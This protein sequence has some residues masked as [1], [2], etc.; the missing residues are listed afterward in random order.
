ML[1]SASNSRRLLLRMMLRLLSRFWILFFFRRFTLHS[2]TITT[3]TSSSAFSFLVLVRLLLYTA[4]THLSLRQSFRCDWC[5]SVRWYE[6]LL[7]LRDVVIHFFFFWF[8]VHVKYY[9]WLYIHRF[10]R[11]RLSFEWARKY[12]VGV[13]LLSIEMRSFHSNSGSFYLS[14]TVRHF[15]FL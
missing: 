5:I 10:H 7:L 3:T 6:C 14:L 9:S 15:F 12:L 2:S 11:I 13:L 4:H 1:V 8:S